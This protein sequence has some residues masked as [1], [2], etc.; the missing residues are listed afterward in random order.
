MTLEELRAEVQNEIKPS[1]VSETR[2]DLWVNQAIQDIG[3]TFPF[4]ETIKTNTSDCVSEADVRIYSIAD[5]WSITDLRTVIS[6]HDATN[7]KW[8]EQTY[9]KKIDGARPTSSGKPTKFMHL[10]GNIEF[11]Y[12]TDDIYTYEMR[13]QQLIAKLTEGAHRHVLPEDWEEGIIILATWKGFRALKEYEKANQTRE[14]YKSFYRHKNFPFQEEFKNMDYPIE[15][16][17]G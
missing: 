6:L 14:Q 3:T 13:Y 15:V 10:G 12:A 5:D 4:Q 9:I 11:E 7:N 8:M 2:V 1:N 16:N 17:L